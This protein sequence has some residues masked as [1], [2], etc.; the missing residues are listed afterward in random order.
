MVGQHCYWGP[1]RAAIG[2][3][4]AGVKTLERAIEHIR[5]RI[6]HFGTGPRRFGLVHADLRLANLLAHEDRLHIIDFDDCGFSWFLYDFATAVSF[7][8]HEALVPDLLTAWLAGYGR[9]AALPNEERGEIPTFVVLRRIL[10]TAWLAS[11]AEI[12]FARRFGVAYT[13]GTVTLAEE[14]LQGRFLKATSYASGVPINVYPTRRPQRHRDRIQQR[15]RAWHGA[16]L[17]G[18]WLQSAG[19]L[20]QPGGGCRGCRSDHRSGRTG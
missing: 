9:I 20:S 16:A 2:L 14:F 13:A 11:H 10:L 1:W 12:P 4:T 7:M 18:S 19:G 6:G 17:R 5:D 3:D 8:E 15:H